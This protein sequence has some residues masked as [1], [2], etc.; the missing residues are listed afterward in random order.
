[1]VFPSDARRA[2]TFLILPVR[3][4]RQLANK[5]GDKKLF[6][7]C[8]YFAYVFVV[9]VAVVVVV[10]VVVVDDDDSGHYQS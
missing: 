2:L 6:S 8:Y 10:V 1:M 3:G 4:I 5:L 9:V 7:I